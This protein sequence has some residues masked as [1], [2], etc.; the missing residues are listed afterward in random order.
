MSMMYAD[1]FG[2]SRHCSFLDDLT[3]LPPVDNRLNC[4]ENDIT[5]QIVPGETD[6]PTEFESSIYMYGSKTSLQSSCALMSKS[7]SST[8][9]PI[10]CYSNRR[11]DDVYSREMTPSPTGSDVTMYTHSPEIQQDQHNKSSEL[12]DDIMECIQTV[13]TTVT[14]PD[15]EKGNTTH[16]LSEISLISN[17]TFLTFNFYLHIKLRSTIRIT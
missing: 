14:K 10:P 15:A 2:F 5:E 3:S 16:Y 1:E 4:L 17:H 6:N 9:A 13:D 12:L 8:S 7:T 11:A